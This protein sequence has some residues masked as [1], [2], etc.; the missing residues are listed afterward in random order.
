[1]KQGSLLIGLTLI[2]MGG[3]AYADQRAYQPPRTADGKPDLQGVW[4]NASITTLERNPRYKSLVIPRDQ[5]ATITASHPQVVRQQTDDA[6][7]AGTQKLDGSDLAKGRGYNAFWIDPGV[8]FGLVKG[9]RRTSW[10]VDPADGK[11]PYTEQGKNAVEHFEAER[12]NFDGPEARPPADRCLYTGGRIGP[13]MLNG[14]YNN[15][16]IV[17]TPDYVVILVEMVRHARVVPIKHTAATR[18]HLGGNFMPLF[19]DSIGWWE[20]DTLVVETTQFNL[21]QANSMVSLT[22]TSK[23]TER[24]T[25]ASAKQIFYEF[26]VEDSFFYKQPWRGELS[27]NASKDSLYEYA[28]HEGN[29][30]MTGILAGAREQEKRAAKR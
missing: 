25:R 9:E 15:Y 8:E 23:V 11:I 5:V 17:Q 13:P 7:D 10:I 16:Q 30:A 20:G 12:Q 6:E 2:A 4:T 28:C 19:G 1:M 22:P 21:L 18:V 24:F 26:T 14:L 3:A 27:F 29:Y